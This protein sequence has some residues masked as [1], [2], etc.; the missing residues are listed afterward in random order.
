[1]SNENLQCSSEEAFPALKSISI[2]AK[3]ILLFKQKLLHDKYFSIQ[4]CWNCCFKSSGKKPF[5]EEHPF[6]GTNAAVLKKI[7]KKIK[8]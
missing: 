2:T 5:S 1:M 3:R 8:I 6:C 7:L 4:I